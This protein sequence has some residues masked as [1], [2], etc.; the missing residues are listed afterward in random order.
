MPGEENHDE[1]K[2]REGDSPLIH[3][4]HCAKESF[5]WSTPEAILTMV[6]T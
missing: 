4:L 5:V 1:L 3:S 6:T 2:P